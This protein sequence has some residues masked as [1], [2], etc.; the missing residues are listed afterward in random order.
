MIVVLFMN[1]YK[2]RKAF[3]L[4]RYWPVW[5]VYPYIFAAAKQPFYS[6]VDPPFKMLICQYTWAKC[7]ANY[8]AGSIRVSRLPINYGILP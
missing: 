3:A 7:G 4:A 2:L 1:T 6:R 5:E 8:S